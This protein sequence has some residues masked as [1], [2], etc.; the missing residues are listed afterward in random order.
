MYTKEVIE[1]T[2]KGFE[3]RSDALLALKNSA[4]E[5]HHPDIIDDVVS[6]DEKSDHSSIDLRKISSKA[7]SSTLFYTDDI[8][9]IRALLPRQYRDLMISYF[10]TGEHTEH[11][12]EIISGTFAND[13]QFSVVIETLCTNGRVNDPKIKEA[14]NKGCQKIISSAIR[15]NSPIASFYELADRFAHLT[16][17]KA[18]SIVNIETAIDWLTNAKEK[19]IHYIGPDL[20]TTLRQCLD[21]D[22]IFDN[23]RL[24]RAIEVSKRWNCQELLYLLMTMRVSRGLTSDNEAQNDFLSLLDKR[25]LS[26]NTQYNEHHVLRKIN[27]ILEELQTALDNY[28]A[29]TTITALIDLYEL[30]PKALIWVNWASVSDCLESSE[31]LV[32]FDVTLVKLLMS[33]TSVRERF[34]IIA[35]SVGD[36]QF[37][38]ALRSAVRNLKSKKLSDIANAVNLL[39]AKAASHLC[40]AILRHETALMLSSVIGY[41]P[42]WAKKLTGAKSLSFDVRATAFVRDAARAFEKNGVL[43]KLKSREFQTDAE[44]ALRVSFLKGR[45]MKG[46]VHVKLD[47]SQKVFVAKFVE[48]V[49]F[50]RSLVKN[51]K[52]KNA[53]QYTK[54]QSIR[55]SKEMTD[56]ILISGPDDVRTIV[57]DSLRH[58]QVPNRFLLSF[59]NA[60]KLAVPSIGDV[61]AFLKQIEDIEHDKHQL[62]ILRTELVS[63]IK[64]F[65]EQNLTISENRE[66]YRKIQSTMQQQFFDLLTQPKFHDSN[67]LKWRKEVLSHVST[68]LSNARQEFRTCINEYVKR[69]FDSPKNE[70]LLSSLGFRGLKEAMS[71]QLKLALE[72]CLKWMD[73]VDEDT[74]PTSITFGDIVQL[75]L[76][77]HSAGTVKQLSVNVINSERSS[78]EGILVIEQ[79][80]QIPGRFYELL[81]TVS[82]NIIGNCYRHSGLGR[83]ARIR[84]EMIIGDNRLTFKSTNNVSLA[85][86]NNLQHKLDGLNNSIRRPNL[87]AAARDEASGFHKIAWAINR[88]FGVLPTMR[89][90]LQAR[91][92]GI[93]IDIDIIGT[94]MSKDDWYGAN[95]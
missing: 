63:L 88:E 45:Q 21:P 81:E 31:R 32:G 69:H 85:Q 5:F 73:L 87:E 83:E 43:T 80:R 10:Y 54:D 6:L 66:I 79:E 11:P 35:I 71:E 39:P 92:K 61:P 41:D 55:F 7:L 59:D 14:V 94:R 29:H 25:Y 20:V 64:S 15:N 89:V 95:N 37:E 74:R 19:I 62:W 26:E 93:N 22:Y 16:E 53:E 91:P 36:G 17:I 4:T 70:G 46:L 58:G 23:K 60:I 2:Q 9:Q 51:A 42:A 3:K 38:S 30:D 18:E 33:E 24:S 90:S 78:V 12:S 77:E 50:V 72:D 47:S 49:S 34:P 67:T 75:C 13:E 40:A 56:Y 65:N 27:N 68:F 48:S 84:L 76:L 44:S 86:Y 57:S 8:E 82:K 1:R 52:I 28:N